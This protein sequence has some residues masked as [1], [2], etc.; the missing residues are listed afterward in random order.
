MFIVEKQKY[1]KIIT[2]KFVIEKK[3]MEIANYIP[4]HLQFFSEAAYVYYLQIFY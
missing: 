1:E 2:K 4:A 3:I